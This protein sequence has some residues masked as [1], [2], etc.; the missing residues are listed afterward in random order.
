MPG[1]WVAYLWLTGIGYM[2]AEIGL[3]ARTELFV[4]N[5]RTH[6]FFLARQPVRAASLKDEDNALRAYGALLF[7]A[8]RLAAEMVP[9]AGR[10]LHF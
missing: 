2:C 3:I 5:L 1:A 10:V 9:G 4:G 8:P 7:N 6:E